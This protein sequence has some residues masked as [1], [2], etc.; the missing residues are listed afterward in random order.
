[1]IGAEL[2]T[3][4]VRIRPNLSG[5]ASEA[6]AGVKAGLTEMQAEVAAAAEAESKSVSTITGAN[7]RVRV[8]FNEIGSSAGRFATETKTSMT[9]ATTATSTAAGEIE[10]A[11]AGVG[12]A[13]VA[14][15]EELGSGL[16][17]GA[18]TG[19]AA[20]EGFLARA[21]GKLLN[22]GALFGIAFGGAILI[23]FAKD[24]VGAAGSVQ[25]SNE[26]IT[27]YFGRSADAVR[28]FANVSAARLGIAAKD[29]TASAAR[30]G[31]L[32]HNLGIIPAQAAAMTVGLQ[33]LAGSLSL[34]KGID[35]TV[36]LQQLDR[37]MLGNTRGLKQLGLAVDPVSE[38]LFAIRH[39]LIGVNDALTPATRAQA[40][41]GIATQH[42]GDYL[43]FARK[44]AKDYTSAQRILSAEWS[45][46]KEAIG[47]GLTAPLAGAATKLADWLTKMNESGKLEADVKKIT[48][49]LGQAFSTAKELLAPL[50]SAFERLVG[51]LGGA[52]DAAKLFFAVW[53]INKLVG[54]ASAILGP[55]V[56]AILTLKTEIIAAKGESTGLWATMKAG[57]IAT[58]ATIKS[59]LIT[60]GIGALVVAM[61]FAAEYTIT[62]W[63]QVKDFF[64]LLAHGIGD[65]WKGLKDVLIGYAKAAAGEMT[66][67]LLAPLLA[68]L[69][70]ATKVSSFLDKIGIHIGGAAQDALDAV[71]SISLDLVTGGAEQ[72]VKGG[73]EIG[74]AFGKAW[75]Q[76]IKDTAKPDQVSLDAMTHAGT[77]LGAAL[78]AGVGAGAV[79][80]IKAAKA[81][82]AQAVSDAAAAVSDAR[83]NVAK[84]IKDTNQQIAALVKTGNDTVTKAA[85]SAATNLNS[86]GGKLAAAIAK[87]L[88]AGQ[89]GKIAKDSPL[90]QQL[91]RIRAAIASGSGGPEL[92]NAAQELTAQLQTSQTLQPDPSKVKDKV[93]KHVS[94]L[95]DELNKGEITAKQF[96]NRLLAYLKSLGA[97][98]A[99][100]GK[101]LGKAQGDAFQAE[102]NALFKQAGIITAEP[103]KLRD[104]VNKSGANTG[105]KVIDVQ[106]IRAKEDRK[107]AEARSKA[108]E[109]VDAARHHELI[110]EQKATRKVAAAALVEQKAIKK[111]TALTAANTKPVKP[112][113]KSTQ[114]NPGK[115]ATQARD[116]A[117]NG[118]H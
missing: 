25:K 35:P 98:Y 68:L 2:A 40:I 63:A 60:T 106:D 44:H 42:L 13:G 85:E 97:S 90:A 1:M 87:F 102:V 39:H 33:K 92:I 14:A 10:G 84:V 36:A 41:F 23:K 116:R 45:N 53:A 95:T 112:H 8:S 32:F 18:A 80:E 105:V 77:V 28:E 94:A 48:H 79:K 67:V 114:Q 86:V 43:D 38:K 37:A 88:G 109:R 118:M 70:A 111:Y 69:Y 31:I 11:L 73:K 101:K 117:K 3:A 9:L 93:T 22:F 59:A 47:R 7:E 103:K 54:I 55:I 72:A 46:A 113:K 62:H 100:V 108:K 64:I 49:E 75:K 29:A 58:S 27:Q 6:S 81:K 26:A 83:K 76:S 19:A 52:K 110:T 91:A 4:F 96:H 24:L 50:V 65:I 51:A 16:A 89:A 15:G 30:F 99:A 74:S 5:F 104:A 71:K 34:I 115:Q 20:S 21:K 12:A 61:A 78:G 17:R 107:I 56:G 82:L 57:A 66:T